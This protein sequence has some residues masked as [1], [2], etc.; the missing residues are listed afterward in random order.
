[1][2]PTTTN[3]QV[4][5]ERLTNQLNEWGIDLKRF[6]DR[7][8]QASGD[9]RAKLEIQVAALQAHLDEGRSKLE[10]LK[11]SGKAASGELEKGVQAAGV[12]LEKAFARAKAEFGNSG[13]HTN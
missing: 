5:T 13:S 9:A 11:N 8:G 1:M 6:R 7:A 10:E 3:A 4:N 12:S 2:Q